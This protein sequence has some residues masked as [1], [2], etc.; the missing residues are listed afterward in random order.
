MCDRTALMLE[1]GFK[2]LVGQGTCKNGLEGLFFKALGD[3]SEITFDAVR[4]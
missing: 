2:D 4:R 3:R 1:G